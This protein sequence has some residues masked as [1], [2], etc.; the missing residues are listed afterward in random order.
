MWTCS[1]HGQFFETYLDCGNMRDLMSVLLMS[2]MEFILTDRH[3]KLIMTHSTLWMPRS[4]AVHL[5]TWLAKN[6]GTSITGFQITCLERDGKLG[7]HTHPFA[8]SRCAWSDWARAFQLLGWQIQFQ[9]RCC[10]RIPWSFV[11]DSWGW[12]AWSWFFFPMEVMEARCMRRLKELNHAL[13]CWCAMMF[14][15][16]CCFNSSR[17]C[18]ATWLS[19]GRCTDVA[20]LALWTS[21]CCAQS[22]LD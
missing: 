15:N 11:S 17:I 19:W 4:R 12:W 8:T 9:I 3:G 5:Y 10:A 14:V 1:I 20:R 7:A 2:F 21:L 13:G 16:P 22:F 6:N 18:W